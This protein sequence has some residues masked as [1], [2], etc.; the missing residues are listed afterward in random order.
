MI[1]I[2]KNM[3]MKKSHKK[4]AIALLSFSILTTSC[5]KEP[6][7]DFTLDKSEYNAGETVKCTNSSS[8]ATTYKWTF[9]DGQTSTSQNVDYTLNSNTPAGNYTIKLEAKNNK[10]KTSE[11]QKSFSVKA[12]SKTALLTASAWKLIAMTIDPAISIN[13]SPI[14][15]LYNQEQFVPSCSKDDLTTYKA[16]GQVVYDEGAVKCNAGDP[17]TTTDTWSFN[18]TET[19]ITE[20][21][22]SYNVIELTATTLKITYTETING[23]D[24]LITGTF[25]H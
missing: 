17:Q 9:P 7:A 5:R 23:V 6:S 10:G 3:I 20:G 11:A 21:S 25:S 22:V 13:G 19:I 12:V 8:D 1:Q 15:N 16:N 24:Y 18:S 2:T 4:A 14:T